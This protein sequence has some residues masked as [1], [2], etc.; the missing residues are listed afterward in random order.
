M[1][2]NEQHP[3]KHVW[4]GDL[5][6]KCIYSVRSSFNEH[7]SHIKYS[8][9]AQSFYYTIRINKHIKARRLGSLSIACL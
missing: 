1:K 2:K 8:P 7:L 3:N 9:K 6:R 5:N 4:V